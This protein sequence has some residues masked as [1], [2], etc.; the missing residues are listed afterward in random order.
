[1]SVESTRQI[2]ER[3][4]SAHDGAV[5][6]MA[7]DVV[8]TI[9]GSG[10]QHRGREA[11]SAMLKY[12]Y[13][14]AFDASAETTTVIYADGQCALEAD[15]VGKHSGDF[16]GIPATHKHVRVPLC[17]VYDLENDQIKRGRVHFEAPALMAQFGVEP[18]SG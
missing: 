13:Q 2:L 7:S 11:V 3:Y 4:F 9:M 6:L 5:E 15:F 10:E 8:F 17:V 14:I 1:M 12:F 18:R 16:A